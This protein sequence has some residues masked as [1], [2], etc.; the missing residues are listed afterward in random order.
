MH[1]YSTYTSHQ[2]RDTQR[3]QPSPSRGPLR[4]MW[5]HMNTAPFR[6]HNGITERGMIY[7]MDT[8]VTPSAE[9]S[10]ALMGF[11]SETPPPHAYLSYNESNYSV[12][13]PTS[14]P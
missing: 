4:Y 13:V 10:E 11:V 12:I 14:L 9:V 7:A 1:I 3:A 2:P 6:I 8:S 5:T